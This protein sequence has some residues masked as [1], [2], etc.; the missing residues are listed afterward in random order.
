MRSDREVIDMTTPNGTETFP[1]QQGKREAAV[2]HLATPMMMQDIEHRLSRFVTLIEPNPRTMK[3]LVNTYF[4][5]IMLSLL[6]RKDVELDALALWTIL[7]MRWP[8]FAEYLEEHPAMVE[9]IQSMQAPPLS[10]QELASIPADLQQLFRDDEVNAVVNS[11]PTGVKIDAEIVS[12][13][14]RIHV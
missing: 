10:E 13:C 4:V 2:I 8:H 11:A 1:V 12:Q 3:R 7:A 14:A 5:N 9:L 6:S